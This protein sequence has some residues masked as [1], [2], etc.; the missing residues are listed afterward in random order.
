LNKVY[1]KKLLLPLLLSLALAPTF[2]LAQKKDSYRFVMVPKV[3]HPWFDAVNN[4]AKAAAKMIESV[5]GSKVT[6]DYQAPQKAD[7]VEQNQ[8]LER[9]IATKPDGII[10]DLLDG[11][12]NKAVL[13]EAL[14]RKIP[15]GIFDSVPPEGMEVTSVGN[16]F[17]EQA[18]I[19]SERLVK[20]LGGKGEVAI[21][22]GVPT[23]PNHAI[24]AQCHEKTFAKYPG[25]KLVAKGIDNDDI[26]T[27]QKQA[28]AIMQAHPK[29]GGW[30]ACDAAGPVGVGQA[31][32]EAGKAGKVTE[33][34][35]DDL[36]E[37][38]QLIKDGVADSS[39]STKPEMQGYWS[40]I[41]LWQNAQ[42][43][44]TPKYI[45][46]GIAVITKENAATYK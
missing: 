23:A 4:G 8:I 6:I 28:A 3:V 22:M 15:V 35:L 46:T 12:G 21:M 11:K 41:A 5:T 16:D 39:S 31:I 20:L 7:V 2:A 27:A 32:K 37:M 25:I 9:A 18:N 42:G 10:V 44:K 1:M 19:A 45:D 38:V 43:I 36:P 33:V 34:G 24:R 40:V 17:C 29:L 26:E 30:V 13:L 14:K